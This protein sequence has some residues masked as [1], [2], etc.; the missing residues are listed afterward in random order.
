M[1]SF[2]RNQSIAVTWT[3][4]TCRAVRLRVTGNACQ[5]DACWHGEVGKDGASLAELVLNA[6]KAVGADDSSYIVAGGNG[7]GWGMADLQMPALKPEELNNA[8]SFELRKQTPLSSDKLHWGYRLLPKKANGTTQP[9]RLFYVRTEHWNSWLKA[10]N[11]LHHIDALLPAPVALDPVLEGASLIM[12]GG[13][14]TP[15]RYEYAIGENGRVVIPRDETAPLKLSEA[16]SADLCKPGPVND[17]PQAVQLGFVPTIVL[18]LYGLTSCINQDQSTMVPLPD[19]FHARRNI[20]VK[21][22]AACLGVYL[23]GLLIFVLAG[24]LSGHATQLRQLDQSIKKVRA[25]LEKLQKLTDPKGVERI[26]LLKQELLDNTPN[27]PDF[28]TALLAVTQAV[29]STHW[30]SDNFE[31]RDG[32]IAFKIQGPTKEVD[33]PSK[34]EDSRFLGDVT[35]RLSTMNNGSYTQRFE[36][37]A[38]FDTEI[39]AEV[40]RTREEQKQQKLKEQLE[41]EQAALKEAIQQKQNEA[42]DDADDEAILEEEDENAGDDSVEIDTDV[43]ESEEE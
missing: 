38:R 9:V 30:I 13:P 14:G 18:G 12:P 35:E 26:N 22:A 7:Q 37:I 42:A 20:P 4:D 40:L 15:G 36:A 8:L 6:A 31:W 19:R 33:L 11:G 32:Q 5:V 1:L 17:L 43:Q 16:L 41:K 27:R 23:L 10:A 39:E 2:N 3:T 25:E 34:L 21:I 24:N 28:P 29:P